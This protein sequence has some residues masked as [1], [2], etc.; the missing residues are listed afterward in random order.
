M[1]A[2]EMAETIRDW[3]DQVQSAL[4]NIVE[5]LDEVEAEEGEE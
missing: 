3:V 1:T 5:L 2:K 4:D